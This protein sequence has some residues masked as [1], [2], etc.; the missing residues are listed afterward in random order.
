VTARHSQEEQKYAKS[1]AKIIISRTQV[2]W[3]ITIRE[4]QGDAKC[5]YV[6]GYIYIFATPE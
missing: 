5:E 6:K 3:I 2:K 4:P 1:I